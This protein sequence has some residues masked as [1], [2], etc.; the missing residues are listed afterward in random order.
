[1]DIGLS[2]ELAACFFMVE[3]VGRECDRII[4]AG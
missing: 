3:R 2:E 4:R 1:M